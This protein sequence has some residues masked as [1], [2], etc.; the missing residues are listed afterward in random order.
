MVFVGFTVMCVLGFKRIRKILTIQR[1]ILNVVPAVDSTT[2][3]RPPPV[4][5]LEPKQRTSPVF[6]GGVPS[7]GRLS[8]RRQK[9][10]RFERQP[11]RQKR[12]TDTTHNQGNPLRILR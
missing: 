9:S 11:Q 10:C 7:G 5:G 2:P 1:G 8:A 4:Q 12:Q 3:Y 6:P